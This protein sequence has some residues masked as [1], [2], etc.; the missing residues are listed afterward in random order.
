MLKSLFEFAGKSNFNLLILQICFWAFWPGLFF[1]NALIFESRIPPVGKYQSKIFF[2][3]DFALGM[4][5][6]AF[7]SMWA[8]NPQ[9]YDGVY[10][11]IYWIMTALICLGLA[12]LLRHNDVIHC[13]RGQWYT[14]TKLT[15]DCCGYFILPWL[16]ISLGVP[17]LIWAIKEGFCFSKCSTEWIV[18]LCCT[19][20]FVAMMIYDGMHPATKEIALKRHPIDYKPIWKD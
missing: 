20:F 14:P 13:P 4:G 1:I 19:A 5:V 12:L 3:G 11:P 18:F 7:V 16:L 6:I 17:Q 15:H 10:K 8:K 9:A 2:P